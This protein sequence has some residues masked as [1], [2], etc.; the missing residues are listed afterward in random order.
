MVDDQDTIIQ[1]IL[2]Q[3]RG[4]RQDVK[5]LHHKID[6][7]IDQI[8]GRITQE[9][10]ERIKMSERLHGLVIRVNWI[11]VILGGVI[12]AVIVAAL[13]ERG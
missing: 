1:M 9:S 12:V 2:D 13:L 10:N 8:H 3:V 11:Y 6:R 5:D 7:K 4:T